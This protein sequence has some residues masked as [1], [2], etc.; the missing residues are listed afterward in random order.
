M[1]TTIKRVAFWVTTPCSSETSQRFGGTYRL[2]LRGLR[3]IQKETSRSR[4]HAEF[5]FNTTPQQGPCRKHRLQQSLHCCTC[6]V[7][8]PTW[9]L[10]SQSIGALA[11]AYQRLLSRCLFR[12]FCLAI[13]L[14]CTIWFCL[15]FLLFLYHS[16]P[17]RP[18]SS[19]LLLLSLHWPVL[20]T[21]RPML[22][23]YS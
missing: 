9:S 23:W 14:Y 5:L 6:T 8:V 7:G 15:P 3:I 16:T 19:L 1:G 12:G 17:S 11:A 2:H 18:T 4:E 10:L 20:H 21:C 13:A 22:S